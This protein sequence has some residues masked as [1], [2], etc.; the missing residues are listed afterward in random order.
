M[1]ELFDDQVRL[2]VSRTPLHLPF[3]GHLELTYRCN[4]N[5]IH[6]YA[7]GS[8]NAG[9]EFST[10]QFKRVIDQAHAAGCL[11]LCLTG[12]EPLLR[13][14]F[15]ELYAYARRKGFLVSIFT[16]G[17]LLRER[18][19]Q[20][21]KRQPPAAIE[22][23]LNGLTE[24]TYAAVTGV[25]G[26]LACL[27]QTIRRMRQLGLPLV[28]KTNCLKENRHELFAI[29][30]FALSTLG[31]ARP[32]TYP[33]K[34]DPMISPRLNG[35][36]GPCRHRLS[37]P[38]LMALR[39]KDPQVW[40]E[41]RDLHRGYRPQGPAPRNNLLHLCGNWRNSFYVNPF[42]RLKFCVLSEKRSVDLRR[43]P[44]ARGFH[45]VFPK[46][47][48]ERFKS[49]SA[50]RTCRL[51]PLCYHCPARALLECGD[52]EKP[53]GYFCE[54]ARLTERRIRRPC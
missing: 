9:K 38:E 20:L 25:S 34:F 39:R 30:K 6:C 1:K 5:C 37:P 42:G 46:L 31:R 18:D 52:E 44:L 26:V 40:S 49:S 17:T 41:F 50:C 47:V 53:I 36:S 29:K 10:A 11:S 3:W 33:F 28:I 32:H 2:R 21:L 15:W 27:L 54:L 4:L 43:M 13:P 35:D 8:E 12:G 23:T 7:K 19:L 48:G 16:N 24:Q 22:I 14:D 51:R 45:T